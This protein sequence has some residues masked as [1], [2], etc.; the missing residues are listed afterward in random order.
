MK[1]A[2]LK[3]GWHLLLAGAAVVEYQTSTTKLRKFLCMAC[4]GWH[5]AAV[6]DDAKDFR[7]AKR[8]AGNT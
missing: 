2:A 5:L 1:E 4:A 6:I 8:Y 3:T 7:D